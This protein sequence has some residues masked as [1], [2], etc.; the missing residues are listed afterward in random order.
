MRKLICKK[1]VSQQNEDSAMTPLMRECMIKT[2][3]SF[4]QLRDI[5]EK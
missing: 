2:K 3:F 4:Q 1:E 5:R